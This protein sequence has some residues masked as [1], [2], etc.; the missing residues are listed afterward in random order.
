[1]SNIHTPLLTRLQR[2]TSLTA[3]IQ[4]LT[5]E[6]QAVK[7]TADAAAQTPTAT[8]PNAAQQTELETL[9][10]ENKLITSAWFDLTCRLQ[11]NTVLLSRRQ[12]EPPKSWLGRQRLAVLQGSTGSNVR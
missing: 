5:T 3:K 4:T 1:M 2:I 11:S 10:R 9:Q 7:S 12:Q 8:K 6:L